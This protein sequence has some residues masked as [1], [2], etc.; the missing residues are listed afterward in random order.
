MKFMYSEDKID[1]VRLHLIVKTVE[2]MVEEA[3]A[4]IKELIDISAWISGKRGDQITGSFA[5]D[6]LEIDVTIGFALYDHYCKFIAKL[7]EVKK[8]NDS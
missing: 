3:V 8:I 1:D 5:P 7:K 4:D 6:Y 2:L